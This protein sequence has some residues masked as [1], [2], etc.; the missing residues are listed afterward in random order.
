[1]HTQACTARSHLLASATSAL[2]ALLAPTGAHAEDQTL[3][4]AYSSDF[5]PLTPEMGKKFWA[6]IIAK[7]EK[8]NPGAKVL[9]VPVPGSYNDVENKMS[10]LFRSPST[11]PDVAEL[12]NQDIIQWIDSGYLADISQQVANDASWKGMPDS[13]K[14]ETTVDG[15]VYA[16]SHGENEFGLLYDKALFQKA[17]IAMP[18]QP[19][20]WADVLGAARKIK[21]S[22]KDAWP[23]WAQTG[24]AQGASGAAYGPN[25]LLVGSSDPTIYDAKE[26][27]WVVDSKGI[28]EVVDFYR[29][30]SA[31]G[32][33]APASQLLNASAI[34]TPPDSLPK[35][36]I[37]V[38]LAGNWFSIQWIKAISAPY[39][40]DGFKE[41]GFAPFPT[42]E[43]QA[44]TAASTL[45][46]WGLSIYANSQKK[47]LAWKFI[48][49]MQ[50]RDSLLD[51]A[52]NGW[53]PPVTAVANSPE[54][55]GQD[56]FQ[57]GFQ[58]LLPL[59]TGIPLKSGYN[60]WAMGLLTATESVVLDPKVTVDE[61]VQKMTDYVSNQAGSDIIEVKK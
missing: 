58:K 6:N 55:T 40:P 46:G 36:Q 24:T 27:K 26:G 23:L 11:A 14:S 17:G 59:S 32:L 51:A 31:E 39:Y 44:P 37:G 22:N 10:L 60:T 15:K 49:T 43:G 45:S 54:W 21:A 29:T 57:E 28:R 56:P 5:V 13:V 12:S 7:F 33:L 25:N 9:A 18:W 2:L 41:I 61:A 16:I 8:E 53:T 52:L 35:H 38:T 4:V 47:D 3:R 19:K 20:T 50:E 48:Q 1:M 42:N 34:S 30:A